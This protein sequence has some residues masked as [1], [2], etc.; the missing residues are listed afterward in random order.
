[1]VLVFEMIQ[2][3][4]GYTLISQLYRDVFRCLWIN[5]NPSYTAMEVNTGILS[6]LVFDAVH[7]ESCIRLNTVQ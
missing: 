3:R 5:V 1:M 7:L 6:S 2:S 4:V